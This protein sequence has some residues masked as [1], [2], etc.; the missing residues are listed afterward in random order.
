MEYDASGKVHCAVGGRVHQAWAEPHG[1]IFDELHAQPNR[2]LYDVLN[3]AM[4]KRAQ[5]LM[6]MITTAGYD[7]NSICWEQHE[8]ARQVAA[9]M[10]DDPTFLPGDLGGG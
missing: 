8:Y 5:P 2:E 7:R 9:G 10:I 1:I 3:T 4:G 6:I